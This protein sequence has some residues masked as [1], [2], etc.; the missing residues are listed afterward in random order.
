MRIPSGGVAGVLPAV[1]LVVCRQQY[2]PV[3]DEANG[4]G[5]GT[6]AAANTHTCTRTC[7]ADL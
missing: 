1:G 4:S 3:M 6:F 2:M 7:I 5:L